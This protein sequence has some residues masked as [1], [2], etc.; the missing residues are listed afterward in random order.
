MK[1]ELQ[2]VTMAGQSRPYTLPRTSHSLAWLVLS[3][4]DSKGAKTGTVGWTDVLIP[5][6]CLRA[7]YCS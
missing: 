5:V 4:V 6:Q 2:V 1:L 3:K 7:A